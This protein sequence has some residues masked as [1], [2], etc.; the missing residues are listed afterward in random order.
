MA[1]RFLPQKIPIDT[2]NITEFALNFVVAKRPCRPMIQ[3]LGRH[4]DSL[5]SLKQPEKSWDSLNL[6]GLFQ[7]TFLRVTLLNTARIALTN[8]TLLLV[9]RH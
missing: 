5:S 3:P 8:T 9:T 2:E 1:V 6:P 7:G 4:G